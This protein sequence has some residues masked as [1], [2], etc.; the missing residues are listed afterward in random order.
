MSKG[1]GLK[2]QKLWQKSWETLSE[3]KCSGEDIFIG[4]VPIICPRRQCS[5]LINKKYAHQKHWSECMF[6]NNL[7]TE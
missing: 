3:D 7:V 5:I 6:K 1:G 2:T 4:G